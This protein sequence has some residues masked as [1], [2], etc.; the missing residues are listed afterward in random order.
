[1]QNRT[2]YPLIVLIVLGLLL[3]ACQPAGGVGEPAPVVEDGPEETSAPPPAEDTAPEAALPEVVIGEV[4][5]YVYETLFDANGEPVLAFG[6]TTV[7]ED[8]LEYSISLRPGVA[9]HNGKPFN[10]DAVIANFNRWFDPEDPLRGSGS[11]DAWV[12][13]FGGFKGELGEGGKPK[14]MYD[15]IEKV[16]E[17]TI[18][19]HLNTPDESFLSKLSDSAFVIVSPDALA[20]GSMDGGTGPYMVDETTDSGYMLE[21]NENY[22]DSGAVPSSGMEVTRE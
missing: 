6:E 14:S 21:P 15:G 20:A 13:A 5:P 3:A 7:S 8:G 9:F 12:A 10:A 18:M 19:I 22:W 17:L 2:L 11:F 4:A 1:M 16:D